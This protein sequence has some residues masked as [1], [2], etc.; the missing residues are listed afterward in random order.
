MENTIIL[1]SGQKIEVLFQDEVSLDIDCSLR[2]I[3]SGKQE[4]DLY[5][6]NN[7]KPNLD[8]IVSQAQAD[9]ATQIAQG[10]EDAAQAAAESAADA[11]VSSIA[12]AQTEVEEYVSENI[13]PDLESLVTEAL[14]YS[15]SAASSSSAANLSSS[16]AAA[17][18]TQASS[19]AASSQTSAQ[20]AVQ[21][22]LSA[23]EAAQE[24]ADSAALA[25]EKSSYGNI[26][27]IKYTTRTDV[28][29]GGAW[30]D[31][32][33]YS[34]AAFP[35]L[36]QMLV[37]G[38]LQKTDYTT[39]AES[40]S[41]NGSC[42]F[43]AL[44]ESA[45]KF[46]VPLLK[47]VYIK[48]GQTPSMFGAESLPNITGGT[49]TDGRSNYQNTLI[50]PYGAFAGSAESGSTG[51]ASLNGGNSN[52][53]EVFSGTFNA[54]RSSSTYQDDAKV[55]PEH[56]VYKA[57]VV[58]YSSAAEASEAQAAEFIN[59]LTDK[60]NTEL[61]N[62]AS[63]G[64]EFITT[65]G[66]PSRDR[67][68]SMPT[69]ASGTTYTAPANGWVFVRIQATGSVGYGNIVYGGIS[70]SLDM[71]R[72]GASFRTIFPVKKGGTYTV[73]YGGATFNQ[74]RFFYDEGVE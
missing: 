14:Q 51:R 48:S 54:S 60:A 72:T 63:T 34:K 7:V 24:A 41:T 26:G 67:Y 35:D 30:C 66:K 57:Y 58:L 42:G 65:Q 13:T 33:E 2:Y 17:Y 64:K 73:A 21:S 39:F 43:F 38:D 4:L 18:A 9:M 46:K 37:D 25:I 32:T 16:Q 52:T 5:V 3:E 29:N 50:A 1:N 10:V 11:I 68:V 55:N 40:V 44:D 12:Q 53:I 27:D 8:N 23:E 36:Y 71:A 62:V 19:S 6:K 28:P 31:G 56:V 49:I 69:E 47:D 20:N 22:A 59:A 45:Q 15:Q 61:D 74:H 70:K